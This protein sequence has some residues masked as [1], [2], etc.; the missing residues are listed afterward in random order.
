MNALANSV[1][2]RDRLLGAAAIRFCKTFRLDK[3]YSL[4]KGHIQLRTVTMVIVLLGAAGLAYAQTTQPADS[5][6]NSI[7]ETVD[8]VKNPTPWM[9]WG[10]DLRLR[11]VY[12]GNGIT[13][14]K[15][16]AGHEIHWQRQRAR[17]WTTLSPH[18]SLDLNVRIAWEGKHFDRPIARENWAPTSTVF[19]RLNFKLDFNELCDI[20]VTVQAGRQELILGERWLVFEGGPLDGSSTIYFD[21]VRFTTELEQ[22]DTKVDL[23]Y[24]EQDAEQDNWFN[25]LRDRDRFITEQDET[26][27]IAWITN[28]SIPKTQL[29]GYFIYKKNRRALANGDNGEIYTFGG[30]ATHDLTDRIKLQGDLAGQFGRKNGVNHCALGTLNRVTYALQDKWKSSLRLDYEY[31]SG[32]D[33]GT[34]ENEAFDL[35]WGRWP[36]FSELWIYSIIGENGRIAD[37]TN[38]HRLGFGWTGFPTDKM[39]LSAD[40]HLLFSDENTYRRQSGFSEN[41]AFRGQLL[42]AIMR[43]KFN[44][45]MAGHLV[46]EVFFP[47]DYYSAER[48]DPGAFVRAELTFSF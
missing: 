5:E 40:Y 35:L 22:I 36:R 24:L 31:L 17:W 11:E 4:M 46:G 48:N 21:A 27:A 7:D 32:D 37:M 18:E 41:G 30:M 12:I 44:R 47:G 13:F 19:D 42:T 8:A 23:I 9:S 1:I 14:D 26:G 3:E 16:A 20:P 33:P 34:G 25:P 29:D 6:T 45:F 10:A 43:Y 2:Q 38:M 15:D 28:K 39:Q